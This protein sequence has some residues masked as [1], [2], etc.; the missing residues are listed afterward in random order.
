MKKMNKFLGIALIFIIS[1]GSLSAQKNDVR[2]DLNYNYSFPVSGFKNDIISNSSPRG[3]TGDI[4]YNINRNWSVGLYGGFQDYYQKYGRDVYDLDKNEQISAVISNSVQTTPVLAKVLF[5]PFGNKASFIQ[6]YISAA[7]GANIIDFTQYLGEF[8][9][10]DNTVNF[11]AQGGI[12][13]SIPFGKF[14]ASGFHFGAT[15]NYMP[16]KDDGYAD[17]NNVGIEAGLHFRLK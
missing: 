16:Y 4:L 17:L 3:F 14:S 5:M 7:A 2:V 10:E 1:C 6:P 12:G 15:Y 8:G 13:L 11:A 9:S